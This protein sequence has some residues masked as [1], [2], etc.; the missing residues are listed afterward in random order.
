MVRKK[1]R[2]WVKKARKGGSRQRIRL[3]DMPKPLKER[4]LKEK[5][6]KPSD[7]QIISDARRAD[8]V[9]RVKGKVVGAWID[10]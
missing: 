6:E 3:P 10:L 9:V 2:T 7:V 5:P 8:P 4:I 1:A